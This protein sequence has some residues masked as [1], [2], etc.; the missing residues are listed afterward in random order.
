[1][2]KP[3]RLA[4]VALLIL[5]ASCASLFPPSM[6]QLEPGFQRE[7]VSLRSSTDSHRKSRYNIRVGDHRFRVETTKRIVSEKE[8][9]G[10]DE[11]PV[12]ARA[13]LG[14][15]GWAFRRAGGT[16]VGEQVMVGTRTV[17]VPGV[18]WSLVCQVA[19]IDK[20][21]KDRSGSTYTRVTEGMDCRQEHTSDSTTIDLTWRF[22]TGSPTA[23]DSLASIVDTLGIS[24][25]MVRALNVAMERSPLDSGTYRLTEEPFGKVLGMS[26][27]GGW[28]IQHV[29]G[30]T[31]AALR[32]PPVFTCLGDCAVDFGAATEEE[33]VVLRF[34]AAALMAPLH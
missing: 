8:L 22:R 32:L 29:D 5:L 21:E 31:V 26:R 25:R 16:T 14:F 4:A 28:R 3:A 13:W 10:G 17:T 20:R 24:P 9:G 15:F 6:P 1:M 12:A 33:R 23:I 7:D 30:R 11:A 18:P 19:W 2:L 27:S 34:I